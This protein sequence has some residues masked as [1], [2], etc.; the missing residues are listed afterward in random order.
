[1][2]WKCNERGGERGTGSERGSTSSALPSTCFSSR[3][4]FSPAPDPTSHP[5]HHVTGVGLLVY[6][7]ARRQRRRVVPGVQSQPHRHGGQRGGGGGR[8]DEVGEAP[9]ERYGGHEY[10]GHVQRPP[11][12]QHHR[13]DAHELVVAWGPAG[14]DVVVVVGPGP[15]DLDIVSLSTWVLL[16][17][18]AAAQLGRMPS[19][20][21]RA[22]SPRRSPTV[23][24]RCTVGHSHRAQKASRSQPSGRSRVTVH[25][26]NQHE[27]A[28]PVGRHRSHAGK[29][30]VPRLQREALLH[31]Y[32]RLLCTYLCVDGVVTKRTCA[33]HRPLP[34][35][36]DRCWGAHRK[37]WS[38]C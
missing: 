1:M 38:S 3:H 17:R 11:V 20:F 8:H 22:L 24:G 33:F 14:A 26:S 34:H 5:T 31:R 30:K 35:S 19:P 28:Q 10:E 27:H 2:G 12:P 21:L 36:R 32:C 6:V 23:K 37:S 7:R 9:G 18:P 29:R 25:H 4:L 15:V 16:H 13:A